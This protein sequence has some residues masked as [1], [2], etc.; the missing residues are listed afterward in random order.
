MGLLLTLAYY[1]SG[2]WKRP[3]VRRSPI[4]APASNTDLPETVTASNPGHAGPNTEG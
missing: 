4:A 1:W 3:V 2:Y